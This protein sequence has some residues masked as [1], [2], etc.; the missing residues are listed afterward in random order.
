MVSNIYTYIFHARYLHNVIFRYVTHE[1]TYIIIVLS[2]AVLGKLISLSYTSSYSNQPTYCVCV[3][4][5]T[6]SLVKLTQL[7]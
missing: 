1:I 5:A 7:G 2:H 4:T 6:I 3:F